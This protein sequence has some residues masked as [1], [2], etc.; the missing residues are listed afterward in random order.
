MKKQLFL[1]LLIVLPSTTNAQVDYSVVKV[2]EESGINFTQITTDNDYVCMPIVKRTGRNINWISNR[3]LDVSVDGSQIAYLSSRGN[4]TNIFIKDI[5]KQGA[6]VQRTNRQA[7]LDFT[8]SPDGKNICFSEANGKVNQIFQTS[9]TSGYICRQITSG[10]KDYSPVYSP[11]MKTIF[12]ARMENNGASIWNYDIGSNFL[13]S[14]TKGMN[15][16]PVKGQSSILC[17]RTNGEG[18]GEIW[19]VN[20]QTG[21]EE[22][23]VSD[24]SRSFTTPSLSPD[25][26]W[27][28]FVGSNILMNG[29]QQYYNTDIF[30]CHIDGTQLVQLTYHAADDISPVWS[31]DGRFIY[32]ISQRGS[33]SGTANVWR[34]DFVY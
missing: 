5:G 2:N 20:Y 22:C 4:N 14:Y 21:I 17:S 12:F 6:S 25:G 26:R 31:R 18:R 13:S 8:Y 15:P 32:F 1:L 9:A 16:F 7:V 23:I 30:A 10:N 28:L 33:S 27:I 19:R 24:P 11:D 34:M 29:E 3:I